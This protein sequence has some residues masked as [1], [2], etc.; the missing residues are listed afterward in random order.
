MPSDCYGSNYAIIVYAAQAFDG[1][2]QL[3]GILPIS[4]VTRQPLL[5]NWMGASILNLKKNRLMPCEM[6]R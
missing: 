5:W 4:F 3:V 6:L 2:F 1:K